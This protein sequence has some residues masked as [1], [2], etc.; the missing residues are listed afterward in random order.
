MVNSP[1]QYQWHESRLRAIPWYLTQPP[2]RRERR[3]SLLALL[4]RRRERLGCADCQ[5]AS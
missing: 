1:L 3:R 5:P 4:P 2:E